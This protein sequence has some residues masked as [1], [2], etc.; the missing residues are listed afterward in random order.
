MLTGVGSEVLLQGV[1]VLVC[2]GGVGFDEFAV[3]ELLGFDVDAEMAE[4]PVPGHDRDRTTLG[5]V[6]VEKIVAAVSLDDCGE[7][8]SEVDG[9]GDAGVQSV[10]AGRDDLVGGVACDEQPTEAVPV[11]D[12]Y[13]RVPHTALQDLVDVEVP[14]AD[15]VQQFLLVDVFGPHTVGDG[16]GLQRPRVAFVLGDDRADAAADEEGVPELAVRVQGLEIPGLEM[17]LAERDDAALALHG[18]IHGAAHDRGGA[19]TSDDVVRRECVDGAVDRGGDLDPGTAVVLGDGGDAPGSENLDVL[20]CE[21]A[22]HEQL[23]DLD[24]GD[25]LPGV[26]RCGAV[27]PGRDPLGHLVDAG[28]LPAAYLPACHRGA[29]DDIVRV[30]RGDADRPDV[31][32]ETEPVEKLHAA[33]IRQ[34]HLRKAGRLR[35]LFDEGAADPVQAEFERENHPYR[36]RAGNHHRSPRRHIDRRGG[37]RRRRPGADRVLFRLP[38]GGMVHGGSF[39]GVPPRTRS[40]S[41]TGRGGCAGWGDVASPSRV[42]ATGRS[43]AA[44]A[45]RCQRAATTGLG[46]MKIRYSVTFPSSMRVRVTAGRVNVVPSFI[47]YVTFTCKAVTFPSNHSSR[48]TCRI[49]ATDPR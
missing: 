33:R 31:V 26:R 10:S 13:V 20:V 9:I 22:T 3:D 49:P 34:V 47:V 6:A 46:S 5:F 41:T 19:V 45:S 2:F 14:A 40:W 16:A 28:V 4:R 35:S 8:P 27:V 48:M 36:A 43:A 7:L 15:R 17:H 39:R 24:L 12:E 30:L 32:D 21:T 37:V 23:F 44:A 38:T 29:E 25:P 1:P 42:A 18:Q 11:G